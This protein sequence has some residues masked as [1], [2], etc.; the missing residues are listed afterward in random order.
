M[1]KTL[2]FDF[3]IEKILGGKFLAIAGNE[4]VLFYD[5]AGENLIGKIDVEVQEI[6][7]KKDMFFL[8]A[9]K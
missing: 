3:Y 7:W 9:A 5:W 2:N 6:Y 4:F 1:E 8:K